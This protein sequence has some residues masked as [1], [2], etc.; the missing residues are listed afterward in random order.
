MASH[1]FLN[2]NR[3]GFHFLLH[4]GLAHCRGSPPASTAVKKE[5]RGLQMMRDNSN[6]DVACTDLAM[7][8]RAAD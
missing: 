1:R 5:Q 3:G 4:D 2:L 7:R 6:D 8:P